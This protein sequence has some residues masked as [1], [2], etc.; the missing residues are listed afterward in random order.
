MVDLRSLT[1]ATIKRCTTFF[2]RFLA[3]GSLGHVLTRDQIEGKTKLLHWTK[4]KK[5]GL[6]TQRESCNEK[7]ANF[8]RFLV[9]ESR[10][11]GIVSAEKSARVQRKNGQ[12]RRSWIKEPRHPGTV[13]DS[14]SDR[15][16]RKNGQF[17]TILR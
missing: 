11:S 5:R 15:M 16:Q 4:K 3:L 6:D 8:R 17:P 7:M 2:L 9:K 12:F 13:S 14:K 1:R 10:H